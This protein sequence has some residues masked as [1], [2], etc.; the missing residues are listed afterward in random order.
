MAL[1]VLSQPEPQGLIPPE[2]KISDL[3]RILENCD[4]ESTPEA[5]W[6]WK[7]VDIISDIVRFTNRDEY[8]GFGGIWEAEARQRAFN[9]IHLVLAD[10]RAYGGTWDALKGLNR[11]MSAIEALAKLYR[12]LEKCR[13]NRAIECGYML[14]E[15]GNGLVAVHEPVTGRVEFTSSL[16]PVMLQ[17]AQGRALVLLV[18]M[19][20][21]GVLGEVTRNRGKARLKLTLSR[22]TGREF[23]LTLEANRQYKE[24]FHT[25][26]YDLAC[27]LSGVFGAELICESNKTG[28]FLVKLY[29][30]GHAAA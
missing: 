9:L 12:S 25:P 7:L 4:Q 24:I 16:R 29:F 3:T 18:G 1:D 19:L 22:I 5:R 27:R 20:I 6:R 10:S 26:E 11:R 8:D 17:A 2:V 30:D 14:R 23:V 13:G 15:V 21:Q 28:G